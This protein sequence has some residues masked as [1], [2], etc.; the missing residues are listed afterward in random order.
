MMY[1]GFS[2][3]VIWWLESMGFCKRGEGWRFVQDGAT[4][5]EGTL[6]VNTNGGS[7]GEGRIHGMAHLS[8]AVYQVTGRAGERQIKDIQHAA[9]TIGNLL[10]MSSGFIIS[11]TPD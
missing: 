8:E 7:L 9:V 11:G 4:H 10:M 2:P 3:F 6:P 1:D 5:A